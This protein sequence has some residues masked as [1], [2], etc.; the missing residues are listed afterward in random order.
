MWGITSVHMNN[1]DMLSE[2]EKC[3]NNKVKTLIITVDPLNE[4]LQLQDD[5]T[6]W[7]PLTWIWAQNVIAKWETTFA[8]Q[9]TFFIKC[10]G[11]SER[12]VK[13][14]SKRSAIY[15]NSLGKTKTIMEF[16]WA[17]FIFQSSQ[18]SPTH[19]QS[20]RQWCYFSCLKFN[21]QRN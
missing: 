20:W 18:S 15:R 11:K 7:R 10:K 1:T 2:I 14:G 6:N 3:L 17:S 4:K 13:A 12:K 8:L 5:W 9:G 19:T 16:F 21:F